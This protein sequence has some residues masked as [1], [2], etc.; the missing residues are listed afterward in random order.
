M[1]VIL[2]LYDRSVELV[3]A[4]IPFYELRESGIFDKIN[5]IKYDVPNDKL[6]ML[7]EYIEQIDEI[8]IRLKTALR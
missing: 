4:E 1:Q 6:Q 5:R 3:D 7:D 8:V 2:H